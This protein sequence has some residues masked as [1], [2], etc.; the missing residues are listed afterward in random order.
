MELRLE[1]IAYQNKRKEIERR[2]EKAR[3]YIEDA[4]KRLA[5]RNRLGAGL[6]LLP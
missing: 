6:F 2:N 5:K 4:E 3:A 1:Y